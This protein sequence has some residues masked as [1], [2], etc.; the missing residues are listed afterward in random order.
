VVA[1]GKTETRATGDDADVAA[2]QGL[3]VLRDK[4]GRYLSEA[5]A[6]VEL[7]ADGFTFRQ[8]SAR[9]FIGCMA[10]GERWTGVSI[11][12]PLLFRVPFSDELCRFIAFNPPD[13]RFGNLWLRESPERDGT[14]EILYTHELLGDYLDREELLLAVGTV[15]AA[16]DYLDNELQR[17]FGGERFH[18]DVE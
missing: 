11:Q 8:G 16:A 6:G 5:F 3:M 4:V 17:R 15:T 2:D 7:A 14:L 1:S 9:V 10:W 13:F 12:V 18:E